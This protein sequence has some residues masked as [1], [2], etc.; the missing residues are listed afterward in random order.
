[1]LNLIVNK[2]FQFLWK[3]QSEK[4]TIEE[5]MSEPQK[6]GAIYWG[7]GS[8]EIISKTLDKEDLDAF[9]KQKRGI[10]EF[11]MS[12]QVAIGDYNGMI[13]FSP[14][15]G[16][17]PTIVST[18]YAILCLCILG[19]THLIDSES[20]STWIASLQNADG[21]FRGDMYG[22]CDTRFSYCAL[23]SLTI[24]NKLDKIHLERCLNFLLRCYNLDG[25]FGSIP[26]SESHAAYTFCCVASLALLNAL[27]YIDIE[28][29]AFWLCERQLAC[30]GFNG[31]PEKAPD[32]CYSW[33]IYSVLFII[34]KT[35]Y[36]N[37]LAL[38]KY[39]LNAQDIEE[40]GISDRPGDISD[41]FHTFFGLSALSIIQK[42]TNLKKIDPIFAIPSVCIRNLNITY[43]G[44][45]SEDEFI[46]DTLY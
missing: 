35:H 19:E 3:L 6:M 41:V 30:G 20:L 33:W 7:L 43:L 4:G 45:E 5:F 14:N 11:I 25:A 37:K 31:R 18:H 13:G 44:I 16:Y 29:L 22:E 2:H 10:L 23:S 27:H 26:C 46:E 12:C 32:V 38:E 39:I 34:G 17:E 24:L 1:M 36:I 42:K 40:G 9:C 28:K 8:M 21:S 15:I